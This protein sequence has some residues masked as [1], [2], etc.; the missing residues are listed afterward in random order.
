MS[1]YSALFH[2][3][4]IVLLF[5]IFSLFYTIEGS[6]LY[7]P[8]II[9]T[10]LWGLCILYQSNPVGHYVLFKLQWW[11][12]M[13]WEIRI[14]YSFK[15]GKCL[16]SPASSHRLWS[17]DF[18]L[19][20]VLLFVTFYIN[21]NMSFIYEDILTKFAGNVYGYANM[22]LQNFGLILKKKGHHCLKIVTRGSI[23]ENSS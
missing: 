22:S 8:S 13:G 11:K 23:C 15:I 10:K 17:G 4:N 1:G 12:K 6:V 21:H 9:W 3:I 14:L 20:S 16:L 5:Q 19:P 7:E 18:N 2:F